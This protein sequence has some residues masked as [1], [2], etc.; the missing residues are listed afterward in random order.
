MK[1]KNRAANI[2]GQHEVLYAYAM[3]LTCGNKYLAGELLLETLSRITKRAIAYAPG[4]VGFDIWAMM[5]MREVFHETCM[6]ADRREL[7]FMFYSG[8][9]NPFIQLNGDGYGLGEQLHMM[10][11][12]TPTQAAVTTLLLN[13]YSLDVIA[14]QVGV[15]VEGVKLQI[16]N[17]RLAI[18]RTW[19]C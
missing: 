5:V 11:R 12:L 16:D 1:K 8:T 18:I 17:A 7:Y 13:G 10:S 6:D 3:R 14:E 4:I 15:S 9:L 19:G 2:I